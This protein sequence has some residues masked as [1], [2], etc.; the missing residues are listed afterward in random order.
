MKYS[1][2]FGKTVRE[3]KSD[4]TLK[5]HKL[6][7]QAGFIRESRA[8]RYFMLPLGQRVQDKM[9][10]IIE[11][12]M[13]AA[14]AQ[15]M[16]AP[17]LHPIELWQETNR[18]SAGGYELMTVTDRAG[19]SFALGGTAEEMF[20]DVVRGFQVSY[21]DLPMTLYQFGYKFRDELRARGGLLRVREFVMKDAYSFHTSNEDFELEYKNMWDAYTKSYT[22]L[23]LDIKVVPA[24]NGYFGGDYC[25]EFIVE[26]EVGESRYFESADGN[27]I[28]HEDIARFE[29]VDMNPDEEIL[30]LET[31]DQPEWVKTMEDNQKHYKLP[32]YKFLKNVVYKNRIDG[33]LYIVTIRGD[34]DVNK[35]KLEKVLDLIGLLEDATPEDLALIGTKPG[36]VHSWGL[37]GC[38]YVADFSLKTVKNF[39]GGQK[40]DTKDTINVN[41]G[42][43]FEHSI[44]ADV[45]VAQDGFLAPDG[46]GSQLVSKKGVE[47]G[48]IFQLGQHYSLK[49]ANAAFADADGTNKPYYMGCYGIGVGRTLATIVETMADDSGIVWPKN[50]APYQVYIA[51]LDADGPVFDYANAF[52]TE[53]EAAGIE[54]LLDDRDVRPGVKF[55]DADLIGIP[56]RLVISRK[57]L[58]S[59]QVETKI[60][61]SGE[62]LAVDRDKVVE[63]IKEFYA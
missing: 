9:I 45:A 38:T 20:V 15:K 58:E 17:V 34:L 5:S 24:D 21:K 25:H 51:S 28:A 8:G 63:F 43:D 50:I 27:Y 55:A 6:L 30:P 23:G 39:V 35:N 53:L 47:V 48:N 40:S 57:T 13:D 14:G 37:M 62:V 29:F 44:I 31:I 19:A 32:A 42:R 60:R 41:Y 46:K 7:Y 10:A 2:L 59:N 22:T 54:V 4:M 18:D 36:F 3:P 1:K 12:E 61:Q 26:S 52:Y 16:F 11:K 33:S 49:M 56:L